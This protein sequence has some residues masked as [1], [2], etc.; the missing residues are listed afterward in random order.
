MTDAPL[1]Q[2]SGRS[3]PAGKCTEDLK[4]KVPD[5]VLKDFRSVTEMPTDSE[6]LRR[7]VNQYLYG[8]VPA[9]IR[10]IVWA[11]AQ[12]ETQEPF[13]LKL[14]H[15]AIYGVVHESILLK[16]NSSAKGEK[17]AR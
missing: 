3:D 16:L 4:T 1:F 2:R 12:Q 10:D 7:V 9:D 8:A 11:R 5:D 14:L 17:G 6:E 15:R 13:L